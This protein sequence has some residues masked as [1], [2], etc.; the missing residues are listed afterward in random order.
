[1]T[2]LERA[3][4][5]YNRKYFDN[6]LPN[7]PEAELCWENTQFMGYYQR[8]EEK[9]AIAKRDQRFDRVWKFTLLHEMVHMH[10]PS[11]SSHGPKFQQEMLRLAQAGA[12]KDLW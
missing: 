8:D 6:L 5:Q 7:P 4:R 9:I 11:G 3:F 1:M 10:L 2:K 12:F